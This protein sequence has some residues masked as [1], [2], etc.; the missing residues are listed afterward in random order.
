MNLPQ[1]VNAS[2]KAIIIVAGSH[3]MMRLKRVI[4]GR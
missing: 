2:V 1:K 3:Q 4:C